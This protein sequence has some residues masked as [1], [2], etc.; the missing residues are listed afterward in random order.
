MNTIVHRLRGKLEVSTEFGTF[1]GDT[2]IRLLEAI[3]NHGSISQAA[4]AV[5][6][7]YKA[8]WDAIDTMN[9]LADQ[10]LVLRSTGGKN[11]G[12]T[13]ITD[14]GRKVIALYRVLEAEYQAALDRLSA[15]MN[16][17]EASDFK[18]FSRLLKHMSMKTSARNQFAGQIVGLREGHVDYEVRLKLDE[19]NEIVAVIT[20]ESAE[21]MGL[22]IGMEL[23]ALVKSSSVLLL[24]DSNLRTSAR[25]HLWGEISRIHDGPVNAEITLTMKSGKSICAVVTHDSVARLGLAIGEQ[26]CAVFKASAVI[27][28]EYA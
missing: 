7:S 23:N 12:G 28:C 27:L 20:S 10:P 8:A 15:S 5:P 25:N 11:G 1:L 13:Q 3:A 19:E 22:S 4:K 18:Q 6:L 14:Y 24:N 26:A 2:R 16:D 21:S 17:G 9:N